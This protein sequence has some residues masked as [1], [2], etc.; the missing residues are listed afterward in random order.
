MKGLYV[1]I[2][3]CN[4]I[5]SY[6]DFPK[7]IAKNDL[8]E[9]YIDKLILEVDLY[10]SYEVDTIFIGGGTPNSLP[11][12]LLEKLLNKLDEFSKNVIEYTIE[13]NPELINEDL[14]KLLSKHKINR[15]SIGCQTFNDNLLKF[16]NRKHKKSDIISALTL[17]KKYNI[18]NINLDLM[19]GIPYQTK[20]DI[21]NDIDI[22]LK[23]DIKHISYYCLILED[24]TV[25]KY[26]LDNKLI[27]IPDDDFDADNY[28]FIKE[29]LENNGFIHYETSNYSKC[30]YESIHNLKYWDSKE[31]IGVGAGASGYLNS[32]RYDNN[33]IINKY[34][35]I[36]I[37][38]KEFISEEE[39]KK[40]FFMLGLRKIEGVSIKE[41]TNRFNSDPFKEFKL[42]ELIKNNLIEQKD[43]YIKIKRDKLF[44]ANQILIEFVGEWNEK[45]RR[46]DTLLWG[47]WF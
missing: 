14:V 25:L 36:Y 38:D 33:R 23:L 35:D 8:K 45:N 3:F 22:A 30:G 7:I 44:L 40:E 21:K 41:Y 4:S 26:K 27:E 15:V 18:F 24:K 6:C 12:N 42:D 37:S 17:L 1:H 16:L 46:P 31:Y 47:F 19:F 43:D 20:E 28:Y 10:K 13:L 29:Q 5:C 39:K 32:Y 11:L 2:P 34:L 9:A